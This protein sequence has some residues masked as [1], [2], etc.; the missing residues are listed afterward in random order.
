MTDPNGDSIQPSSFTAEDYEEAVGGAFDGQQVA[1]RLRPLVQYLLSLADSFETL[2]SRPDLPDGL[3]EKL[4]GL[5]LLRAQWTPPGFEPASVGIARLVA[6][7]D[8]RE[9]EVGYRGT[10][11]RERLIFTS[12][13]GEIEI[14]ISPSGQSDTYLIRCQIEPEDGAAPI[15][16]GEAFLVPALDE[17]RAVRIAFESDGFFSVTG[18]SGIYD[19]T[20]VSGT[21]AVRLAGIEVG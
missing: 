19:L 18:R 16:P 11:Q 21:R 5:F 8:A 17:R 9:F 14:D 2:V 4:D 3:R 15:E 1:A 6:E 12:E 10:G 7:S 13:L 20:I